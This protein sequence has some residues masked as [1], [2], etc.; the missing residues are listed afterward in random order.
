M[1]RFFLWFFSSPQEPQ[2]FI[3]TIIWWEKRRIPY[4]LFIGVIGA[5]SLILFFVFVDLANELKQ[6]EDAVEPI[7]LFFA[8]IVI[9][10]C[11][12]IGWIV[13]TIINSIRRKNDRSIGS[14]LMKIGMVFSVVVLLIPSTTWFVIWV[15]K[16][17]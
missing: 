6:G 13:E 10:I 17:I 11:Y 14:K 5:I 4:N 12:T 9:N 16:N 2:T 7:A 1:K 8:P 3:K 15:T